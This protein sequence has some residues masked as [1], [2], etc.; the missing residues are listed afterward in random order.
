MIRL[1]ILSLLAKEHYSEYA[2]EY[3]HYS[4]G[5]EGHG[6]TGGGGDVLGV[7]IYYCCTIVSYSTCLSQ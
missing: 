1:E 4:V 2:G 7:R 6:N 3:Y 5:S